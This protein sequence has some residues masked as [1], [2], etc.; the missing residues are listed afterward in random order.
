MF[1]GYLIVQRVFFWKARLEF[2]EMV[3]MYVAG[4]RQVLIYARQD[5][6]NADFNINVNLYRWGDAAFRLNEKDHVWF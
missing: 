5:F 1:L 6:R 4:W 2:S 3:E